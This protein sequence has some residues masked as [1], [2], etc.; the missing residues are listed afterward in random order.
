MVLCLS[1]HHDIQLGWTREVLK[2]YEVV[3]MSVNV[4]ELD[5]NRNSTDQHPDSA[6]QVDVF[7]AEGNLEGRMT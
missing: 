6:N 3:L 1:I 7:G 5:G 4:K 2:V